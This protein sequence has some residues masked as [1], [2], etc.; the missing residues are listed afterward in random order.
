MSELLYMFGQIDER[1]SPLVYTIRRWAQTNSITNAHPGVWISNFSL[2]CLVIFYLQQV[3]KPVLPSINTLIAQARPQDK[4]TCE[5]EDGMPCTFLRDLNL[6]KFK[7]ENK[8]SLD[9]L[10]FGFFEFYSLFNLKER[11]ISL[12]DG[13]IHFKPDRSA[14]YIINPLEPAL[15][16]SRN[17]STEEGERF[18]TEVKNAA[19]WLDVGAQNIKSIGKK[20]PWGLL[21]LFEPKRIFR[22]TD[23]YTSRI[24]NVEYLSNDTDTDT[25]TNRK[26][27]FK[28]RKVRKEI[29]KIQ[30]DKLLA[31]DTL[32]SRGKL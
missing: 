4:R 30:K 5:N 29:G 9:R 12:N 14:L 21:K 15:N 27:K 26:I 16:V 17:V 20:E 7:K 19:W 3:E 10:L 32:K 31:L 11:A 2:T 28:N 18:V 1:V 6:L 8:D 23:F 24:L 22:S 13:K 25:D